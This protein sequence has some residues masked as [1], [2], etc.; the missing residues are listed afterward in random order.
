MS[1]KIALTVIIPAF[2]EEHSIIELADRLQQVLSA[3]EFAN[4]YE[5]IFV[6]DGS[7]DGT[8]AQ[9]KQCVANSDRVRCAVLRT[10]V[11]KS[12]ALTVAFSQA[13]ADLIVT[14]DADLQDNPEDIPI[15][16][17]TLRAGT[18]DLVTGWRQRREDTASRKL[19]SWLFNFVIRSVTNLDIKD[20]NC[21]FKILRADLARRLFIYGQFHR[22][23]PLQAH[24]IGYRVAEVAIR[25]SERKYGSSKYRT[26]RYEGFFDFLSVLFSLKYGY[27]PLHFFGSVSMFFLIPSAAVILFLTVNH[28]LY[29][30][31][32]TEGAQLLNRPALS[33]AL[34]T[35]LTGFVVLM[36]GFVCDFI[37][38]HHAR[39]NIKS[40]VD[41][42]MLEMIEPVLTSGERYGQGE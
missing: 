18:F 20:Q 3:S 28:I 14:M 12:M 2:N 15:L 19:G 13:R 39:T 37:L 21:G 9:I 4:S 35:F 24:L 27:S 34:T 5:I 40:L 8:L 26:L 41:Y 30:L 22:F 11:G 6:D 1:E 36:T 10:N 7:T 25:N 23:I 31:T 32:G 33:L 38:H 29:V 16:V 42:A 17:K